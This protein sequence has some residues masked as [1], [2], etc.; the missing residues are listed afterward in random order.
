M[1]ANDDVLHPYVG[2]AVAHDDNVLGVGETE[3]S[4]STSARLASA[5]LLADK[6]IGQQALS[7][8]LHFT[9]IRYD[10]LPELDNDAKDLRVNWNWR[11]G[12][13]LDGN[14]GTSY[15]KALAP[16]V[17]FHDR[18][19][20][21]RTERRVFADGGWL[22]HPS[23]RL[24]TGAQRS[25]LE[26]ELLAQQGGDRTEQYGEAGLDYLARSGSTVGLQLRKT[27]GDYPRRQ[28]LGALLVDNSY[29]QEELKLKVNWLVTNKTQLQF[30]GGPVR[31]THDDTFAAR[32]Y[33]GMNARVNA[34]W[35][36]SAKLSVAFGLWR[37]IGALDDVTT[38]YTLNR[39]A[40]IGST[41]DPTEK[42]RIEAQY[43]HE[44]SDYSA[45]A[46]L[47]TGLPER[48]DTVRRGVFKLTYRATRHLQLGTLAYRTDRESTLPGNSYPASGV[49]LFSKYEF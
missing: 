9:R 43:R 39:G 22:L 14:V 42:I 15:V 7:A 10:E 33:S 18:A 8:A 23:W 41:W 1:A 32:D 24:R 30:L 20:N 40:S 31:R 12:T 21:I 46:G 45:T 11:V 38:S 27:N 28:Q 26:Y 35:Q 2:Y 36:S 29:E 5:G 44:T 47:A 4:P 17:N 13:H 19:R 16:F 3:P 48:K 34:N 37:E 49:Q 25:E 6:K